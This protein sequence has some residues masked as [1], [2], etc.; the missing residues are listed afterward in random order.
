MICLLNLHAESVTRHRESSPRLEFSSFHSVLHGGVRGP[1]LHV[2]T[3]SFSV[4]SPC[5]KFQLEIIPCFYRRMKRR[6]SATNR[7]SRGVGLPTE[8]SLIRCIHLDVQG[9]IVENM[10]S[11]VAGFYS[12]EHCLLHMASTT[13][14]GNDNCGYLL[15]FGTG[16]FMLGI[17]HAK[18]PF[19]ASNVQDLPRPRNFRV[20]LCGEG[21]G[22][23][24]R[25]QS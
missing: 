22:W 19:D 16:L 14:S 8:G 23:Y 1:C 5:T 20:F 17:P 9:V 11:R 3:I 12:S 4:P 25:L 6:A 2:D 10:L 15:S 13:K 24:Q 7:R 21:Q 18:N